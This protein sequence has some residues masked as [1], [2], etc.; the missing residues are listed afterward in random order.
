MH[1]K[2]SETQD[3]LLDPAAKNA[4]L[5]QSRIAWSFSFHGNG[6]KVKPVLQTP[7]KNGG[8]YRKGTKVTVQ[9]VALKHLDVLK[10][11][12]KQVLRLAE[13]L[14]YHQDHYIRALMLL[15]YWCPPIMFSSKISHY[16]SCMDT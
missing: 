12:D 6:F 10:P 9:D 15:S 8:G 1:E 16:L 5:D 13:K 11:H 3:R 2:R 7:K 14:S 4:E